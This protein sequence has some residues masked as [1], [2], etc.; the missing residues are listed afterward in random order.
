MSTYVLDSLLESFL[1]INNA[2]ISVTSADIQRSSGVRPDTTGL[3]EFF[4]GLEERYGPNLPIDLRCSVKSLQN[5][6][7]HEGNSKMAVDGDMNIQFFVNLANQT[8]EIVADI[9]LK[10]VPTEFQVLKD[11]EN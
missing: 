4:P 8:K 10:K 1:K 3:N 9:S 2:T 7:I 11:G 5:L 6:K